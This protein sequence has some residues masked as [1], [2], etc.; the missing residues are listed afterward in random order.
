MKL[1]I[2]VIFGAALLAGCASAPPRVAHP[3]VLDFEWEPAFT[4]QTTAF[5]QPKALERREELMAI[6]VR[7]LFDTRFE[8]VVLDGAGKNAP[9]RVA[10]K[11]AET[12]V[13]TTS[14]PVPADRVVP[15]A[16]QRCG[17]VHYSVFISGRE[18]S[19][20]EIALECDPHGRPEYER[21]VLR[22]ADAA[23]KALS[24]S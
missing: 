3:I 18:T 16:V 9:A 23:A 2:R 22:A 21:A 15:G 12:P 7:K 4:E 6:A 24:Q 11:V 19:R 20:E 10:L 8:E 14:R 17:T 13:V 1:S 5:G